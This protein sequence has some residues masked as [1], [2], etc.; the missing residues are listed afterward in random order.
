MGEVPKKVCLDTNV[1][2]DNLNVED[3]ERVIV[4]ITV[5]EELDKLKMSQ[6]GDLAHRARKASRMLENASN[7]EIVFDFSYS[8]PRYLDHT[9]NDN[10]IMVFDSFIMRSRSK[11]FV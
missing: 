10:K 2:L 3:F 6:D 11:Y 9:I 4:P 1:L 7:V 8:L 5:V